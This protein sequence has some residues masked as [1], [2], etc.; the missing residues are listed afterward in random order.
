MQIRAITVE[1][2]VFRH[3]KLTKRIA[4][5]PGQNKYSNQSLPKKE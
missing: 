3:E 4:P 2:D 5:K 1:F